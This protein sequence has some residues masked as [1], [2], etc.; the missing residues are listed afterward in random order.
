ME[1]REIREEKTDGQGAF[2]LGD[3]EAGLRSPRNLSRL[4]FTRPYGARASERESASSPPREA[5]GVQGL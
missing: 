2:V 3:K 4:R 1:R 5:V